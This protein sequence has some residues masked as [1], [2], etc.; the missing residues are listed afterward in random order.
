MNYQLFTLSLIEVLLSIFI[1]IAIFYSA[2]KILNKLFFKQKLLQKDNLALSI[3]ISGTFLSIGIILSEI[4]PSITNIIRISA[5]QPEQVDILQIIKYSSLYLLIGFVIS[6][7]INISVFLL[8]SL[9]TK[10]VNEF[11]EIR[12][13][14]V[15]TAII[16]VTILISV[17]IITKESIAL[18]ISSLVPYPELTNFL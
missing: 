12:N 10:G 5:L 14:N 6:I 4:L 8:F 9:L 15:P 17:T 16:I 7:I 3:F 2:Y 18:L 13:N 11:E 1:S